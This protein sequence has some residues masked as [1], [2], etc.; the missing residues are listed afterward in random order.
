VAIRPASKL[1]YAVGLDAGSASTRCVILGLEDGRL[2]Y[3][4]HGEAPSRGWVKGRI[5]D[6]NALAESIVQAAHEAERCSGLSIESVVIGVGG[7]TVQ[8]AIHRGVYEFGR[9]REIE[10]G[11]LTYA[12]ELASRIRL[13]DDR[14]TLQ[15]LPMDFTIDGRAG[16]RNPK[17]AICR[18]L[19][20][21][22]QVITCSVREHHA[23]ISAVHQSHLAVE[24][25][26]FEPVAGAYAA[27]LPDDRARGVALVD[28]GAHS[29]NVVVY[30]GDALLLAAG[31][32]VSGEHFTRDL[33]W[34]LKI[35]YEDAEHLKREYGCAIL[36]LTGDNSYIELPSHD[37]RPA[38]E[39]RRRQLNEIL[40][41][42]AEELFHYVRAALSH[43]G[44][45]QALLEGVIVTGGG[46]LL[47]GICDMAEV[48][49]NCQARNGLVVGIDRWP[50]NIDTPVWTTAAG[51]GMYAAR[52]KSYKEPK[53]KVPSLANLVMR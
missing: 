51:L 30:D 36:G 52:L 37:G 17:G 44:M 31:F 27:V 43:I 9:P 49:L 21:N 24:E 8:G 18:R 5:A 25:T 20:A 38:R 22:I 10:A 50:E 34:V 40:E 32:P 29:T 2:R 12:V 1:Q 53:R 4:G 48:V 16:Y 11:D 6:S 14:M 28:I 3:L 15:M 23:L 47:T 35:A 26:V 46:A 45:E 41:A 13:E 7:A 42:R 39:A 33:S 19:E